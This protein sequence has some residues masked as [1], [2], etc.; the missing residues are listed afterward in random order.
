MEHQPARVLPCL[1]LPIH[2]QL[3]QAATASAGERVHVREEIDTVLRT[4]EDW[5]Q[6]GLRLRDTPHFARYRT[7]QHRVRYDRALNDL[8]RGGATA[9]ELELVRSLSSEIASSPIVIGSGQVLLSGDIGEAGLVQN[10]CE[11]FLWA[12][13]HPVSAIERAESQL[14]KGAEQRP[15]VYVLQ[16]DHPMPVLLGRAGR[17]GRWDLLLPRRLRVTT[18]GVR[19]YSGLIV[20]E[21]AVGV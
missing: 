6:G 15:T 14:R 21:A 5:R 9:T 12:T 2:V 13:I 4:N 3:I 10:R 16:L 11:P 7:R 17:H 8:G 1:P 18:N 20:K 19:D